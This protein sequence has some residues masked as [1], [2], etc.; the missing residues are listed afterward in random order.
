MYMKNIR[1]IYVLLLLSFV[2]P[3][4]ASANVSITG[5]PLTDVYVN[6]NASAEVMNLTIEADRG[7]ATV[8]I[9]SINITVVTGTVGNIS[10]ISVKNSTGSILGLNTSN[11]TTTSYTIYLG[12]GL[13]VNGTI[14]NTSL[15]IVVNTTINSLSELN[16]TLNISADTEVRTESA[17]NISLTT[18]ENGVQIQDVHA[19]VTISPSN[20]DTSTVNQSFVFIVTPTGTDPVETVILTVPSDF[21]SI[22]IYNITLENSNASNLNANS[23]T[24][25]LINV[26]ANTPTGSPIYIYF[27][28]N[29]SSSTVTKAFFNSTIY[30]SNLSNITTDLSV[31]GSANVTTQPVLN[32]SNVQISKSTAIVN[33]TDYWEFNFTLNYSSSISAGG[34]IQFKMTNWSNSPNQNISITDAAGSTAV[35]GVTHCATLR[36]DTNFSAAGGKFNITNGYETFTKGTYIGSVT[37]N[38]VIQVFLRMVVP[39]G[40]PVS[41]SW[42]TTYGFLFRPY[43]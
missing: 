32:I 14:S 25:N 37:S 19:N 20:V 11:G 38:T 33:G 9:T 28:A 12:N 5:A 18:V 4:F 22:K 8:N 24:G 15:I 39:S 34:I 3:V 26:T 7:E 31:V 35:C 43:Y 21:T 1:L 2:S 36:N 6:T 40:T 41:T 16:L 42:Q 27:T 30:G 10:S 17:V 13:I 23:T 29:T